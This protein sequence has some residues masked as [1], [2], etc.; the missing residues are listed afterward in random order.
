MKSASIRELAEQALV[1]NLQARHGE[2]ALSVRDLEVAYSAANGAAIEG[3]CLEAR[4]GEMILFVGPNG[5]GK[6]TLLKAIAGLVRPLRGAV[7]VLGRDP[8]R[9]LRVRK[10]IAYVPQL[11]ELNINAPL[12]VRDLVALGRYPHLKPLRR[13][14][15]HDEEKIQESLKAVKLEDITDRRLSELSGGQLN[16]A[17]IAR[18][19]AQE[20]MIYL[21]DE[22]FESIDIPTEKLIMEILAREKRKGKLVIV[23]EH[24]ITDMG[25]FDR[26]VLL[27]KRVI[28]EGRPNEVF[29][30]DNI[31]RAYG[32]IK[33][34]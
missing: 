25:D 2:P 31:R 28:I 11:K 24:H 12:T 18:A 27:N 33:S 19:L 9:E 10:L 15:S 29:T 7:S 17:V 30:E 22:P 8:Y 6:T 21:L 34:A 26:A 20:A 23:T 14:N 32:I 16:R 3:V 13:M 5:G 1:N 4:L